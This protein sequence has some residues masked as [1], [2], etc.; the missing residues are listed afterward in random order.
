MFESGGVSCIAHDGVS[1]QG[2]IDL[3][4]ASLPLRGPKLVSNEIMSGSPLPMF[5]YHGVAFNPTDRSLIGSPDAIPIWSP[6]VTK[7]P[8]EVK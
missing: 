8:D 6:L 2:K 7:L 5:G 1:S 3:D 4:Q